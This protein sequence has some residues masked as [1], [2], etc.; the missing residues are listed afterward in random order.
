V[1]EEKKN[2]FF[3]VYKQTQTWEKEERTEGEENPFLTHE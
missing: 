3:R 2:L 1:K